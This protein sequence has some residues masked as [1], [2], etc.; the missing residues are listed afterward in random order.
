MR[1][2][3]NKISKNPIQVAIPKIAIKKAPLHKKKINK[4]VIN[5]KNQEEGH[6]IYFNKILKNN[7][8]MRRTNTDFQNFKENISNFESNIKNILSSEEN[9]K[10]S[11]KYIIGLRNKSRGSSN[12]SPFVINKDEPRNAYETINK[13]ATENILSKTINNGFYD[14]KQR[15][16]F[17]LDNDNYNS[18]YNYKRKLKS[19]L[20]NQSNNIV[21]TPYTGYN[22]YTNNLEPITP[23]KTIRVNRLTKFYDEVSFP[24]ESN[25]YVRNNLSTQS[26]GRSNSKN[27]N[28]L[29]NLATYKNSTNSNYHS[30]NKIYIKEQYNDTSEDPYITNSQYNNNYD[31][32]DDDN[33]DNIKYIEKYN[34]QF[35]P[36]SENENSG[37]K[38]VIIDNM[39]EA[40][41]SPKYNEDYNEEIKFIDNRKNIYK[42]EFNKPK[43]YSKKPDYTAVLNRYKYNTIEKYNSFTTKAG[44]TIPT[45]ASPLSPPPSGFNN[46]KIEKNRFRIKP[47]Y[48]KESAKQKIDYNNEIMK[49][50]RDRFL[51]KLKKSKTNVINIKGTKIWNVRG[52]KIENDAEKKKI[53]KELSKV[54]N[55]LVASQNKNKE[56]ERQLQTLQEIIQSLKDII[57]THK[58]ELESKNKEIA[59]LKRNTDLKE[60]KAKIKEYITQITNLKE[61]N[62]N[63]QEIISKQKE[64]LDKRNNEILKLKESSE[65]EL[66]KKT[67]ESLDKIKNLEEIINKQKDEISTLKENEKKKY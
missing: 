20:I 45:P 52:R 56:N 42:Q 44:K 50:I 23:H 54:K 51:D 65:L 67:E 34:N 46:L 24:S 39:N 55:D 19:D 33:E 8:Q 61:T 26:S 49:R 62:E 36:S 4:D 1:L 3:K 57:N 5:K 12:K 66:Q 29:T 13:N 32:G 41:H 48:N 7:L 6:N 11:M 59:E 27:K 30:G 21:A 64:E 16:G 35:E 15:K 10:K 2:K 31:D 25:I 17:M 14:P 28:I 47:K 37:L 9:R 40:Y 38:E 58:F 63:L 22:G 43:L 18:K 53:E 60:L